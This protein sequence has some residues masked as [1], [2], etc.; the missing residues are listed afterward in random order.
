MKNFKK[1]S[2]EELRNT[3]GG[4]K[5]CT[6]TFKN[7]NGTYTTYSGTCDTLGSLAAPGEYILASTISF[8]NIGN[9][10][11]YDL[12]SNGGESRC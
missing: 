1:L 6:L 4:K 8:C 2:R 5:V 9:G 10:I 11:A 12:S 3:V 7:A